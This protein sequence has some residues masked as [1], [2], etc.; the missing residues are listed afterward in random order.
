MLRNRRLGG[1]KFR[2]QHPLP[3]YILDFY[4]EEARLAI[5]LDGGQHGEQAAY[6]A[7]RSTVLAS[8]GIRVL[9]F[10]NNE[11][12]QQTEAVLQ[13]IWAALFPE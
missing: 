7:A 5:E 12:L 6:D 8:Q 3:P 13:V 10:W 4:C 9:R 2:R 1:R 11:V